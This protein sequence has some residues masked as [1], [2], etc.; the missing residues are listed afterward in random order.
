MTIKYV[1]SPAELRT[2]LGLSRN[3]V[4]RLIECG[5]LKPPILLSPRR[6]AHLTSDVEAFLAARAAMRD[7]SA[8]PSRPCVRDAA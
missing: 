3:A 5:D 2:Q 7:A 4:D 8:H 6:K 1:L